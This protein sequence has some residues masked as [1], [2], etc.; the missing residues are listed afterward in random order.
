MLQVLHGYLKAH[1]TCFASSKKGN[2]SRMHIVLDVEADRW[3]NWPN[4][5]EERCVDVRRIARSNKSNLE[6]EIFSNTSTAHII[7]YVWNEAVPFVI[8][9]LYGRT[10]CSAGVADGNYHNALLLLDRAAQFMNSQLL[11]MELIID[12]IQILWY[13]SFHSKYK[14]LRSSLFFFCPVI[15]LDLLFLTMEY[16]SFKTKE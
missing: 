15:N 12:P 8:F 4:I 14:R 3:S 9:Q 10:L 7:K 6:Y 5:S 2:R 1:N 11:I 16:I 13:F